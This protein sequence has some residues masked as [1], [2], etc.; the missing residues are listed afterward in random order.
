MTISATAQ[1]LRPGV[2]TSTSRP[3]APFDGQVI[4]E[5]D[6]NR[7]LVWDNSAWVMIADTDSPPG[8]QLIKSQS[9]TSG[10]SI[11]LSNVFSSEFDSYRIVVSDARLTSGASNLKMTLGATATGYYWSGSYMTYGASP[12]LT[13]EGGS[14]AALWATG[15]IASTVSSG[16]Y[17]D[18]FNPFLSQVTSYVSFGTDTRASGGAMRNAYAGFLNNSTSYTD[19]TINNESQTYANISVRVYGYRNQ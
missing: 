4:Y 6:T 13:S 1:G 10:S 5:T 3:S 8:L 12:A 9:A 7:V 17:I 14:N 18:I 19:F 16:G 2:C 15:I 11:V